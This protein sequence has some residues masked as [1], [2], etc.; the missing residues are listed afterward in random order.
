MSSYLK[1]LKSLGTYVDVARDIYNY[2][3]DNPNTLGE[4]P[5]T[6]IDQYLPNLD[7]KGIVEETESSD[8]FQ[9]GEALT[10]PQDLF[11]V[12]NQAYV[13]FIV[14]DPTL[15]N[16]QILKRIGLYMPPEIKA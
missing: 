6:V 11:S 5:G 9:N 3:P 15:D 13:F 12:G 7:N 4:T 1:L 8:W 16:S 10:Y 14:R 2:I